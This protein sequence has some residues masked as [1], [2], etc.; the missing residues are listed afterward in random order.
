VI[1]ELTQTVLRVEKNQLE[2]GQGFRSLVECI[3]MLSAQQAT[4]IELLTPK[5]KPK[6]DG[7]GLDELLA[8]IV[9]RD[10]RKIGGQAAIAMG[11]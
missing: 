1:A 6:K 10:C 7:P 9:V 4:L 8:A 5:E 11:G 3:R 2:I